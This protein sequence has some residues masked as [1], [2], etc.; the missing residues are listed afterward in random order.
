MGAIEKAIPETDRKT[1]LKNELIDELGKMRIAS[2]DMLTKFQSNLEADIVWC[3]ESFSQTD[4]DNRPKI[5]EQKKELKAILT[6]I[7]ALKL[8]PH[9][10]RLKD[11]RKIDE[12]VNIIYA[13]LID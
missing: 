4:S 5:L 13:K 11:I 6:E 12:L 10:G 3:I 2:N 1:S 9:K 7:K 8:K